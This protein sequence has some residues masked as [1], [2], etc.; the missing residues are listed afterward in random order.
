MVVDD[1][2]SIRA[3]IRIVLEREGYRTLEAEGGRSAWAAVESLDGRLDLLITDIQMPEGDGLTL[4]RAVSQAYPSIP[5]LLVS[6]LVKPDDVFEFVEK[7][8]SAATLASAVRRLK[9]ARE[10]IA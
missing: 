3:F 1:E 10:K 8:F 7:P 5:I 6:G 4:A 9:G 2:P